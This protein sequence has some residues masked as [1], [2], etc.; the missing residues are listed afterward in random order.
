MADPSAPSAIA[1][2]VPVVIG[3]LLAI[4][5]GVAAQLIT[6]VLAEK[7][8]Y[9]TL[10]RQRLESLLR[11]LYAHS[12]WLEDRF[13]ALLFRDI[14]HDAPLPLDEA[15]VIQVLYFPELAEDLSNIRERQR[16]LRKFIG[17]QKVV[18]L[19]DA[20]LWRANWNAKPYYDAYGEYLRAMN[21]AVAKCQTLMDLPHRPK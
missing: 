14:T 21:L 17:D 9:R 15:Q 13:Q 4:G 3:G 8:E 6:H 1:A 12:Q 5:G 19:A 18:K 7:R 2:A 16:P 20:D 10:R 11:A